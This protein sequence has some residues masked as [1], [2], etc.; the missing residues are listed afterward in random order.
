MQNITTTSLNLPSFP[1]RLTEKNGK[2]SIYDPLRRKKVILTPEEWVRQHFVHFLIST[3]SFPPARIANE[4]SISVNSTS[5]RC[6]TVVFDDFLSPL[7]IIEYKSP[8]LAITNDVINQ[9]SRYNSVLRAP[10]LMISN[11][12]KHYCCQ[13][14]YLTMKSSFLN[15]IPSYHEIITKNSY[16]CRNLNL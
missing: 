12:L 2:T 7:V 6:D 5:K 13:M 4:V 11:G 10:F 14:D 9:I 8:D 16:L 1:V 15:Y 3:R